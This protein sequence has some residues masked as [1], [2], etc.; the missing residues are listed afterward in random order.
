MK[1]SEIMI[2]RK[3]IREFINTKLKNKWLSQ[4]V[5]DRDDLFYQWRCFPEEDNE[6]PYPTADEFIELIY[7]LRE[8]CGENIR[9]F[10]DSRDFYK[11]YFMECA[12]DPCNVEEWQKFLDS[13]YSE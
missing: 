1:G 11:T 2:E 4:A 6:K 7:S 13:I 12:V 3:I 9:E 5:I 10:T 8:Y